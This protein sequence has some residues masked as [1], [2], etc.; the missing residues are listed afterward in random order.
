MPTT[1]TTQTYIPKGSMCIACVQP[2]TT[3]AGLDFKAMPVL[4]T[5]PDGTKAVKCSGF[6]KQY[7]VQHLP[8][9]DTEGG[10]L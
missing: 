4:K 5:Y 8:A 7:F 9:D 3:C 6:S 2:S 1:M 10:A